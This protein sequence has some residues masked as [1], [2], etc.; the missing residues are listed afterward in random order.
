MRCFASLEATTPS[1]LESL[2]AVADRTLVTTDMERACRMLR[3]TK[4]TSRWH[5]I[6]VI[7]FG[8]ILIGG[9]L[10]WTTNLNAE[11]VNFET[12][13]APIFERHCVHCHEASQ[14]KGG[15]SLSTSTHAVAGG[16]SGPA[17]V[18]GK[19]DESLL[20]EYISGEKPE[21]PKNGSPLSGADVD[22]IRQWVAE[23]ARWP[24]GI[25][26]I[27]KKQNDTAWWSLK[28]LVRPEIPC[29]ESSWVRTPIDHFLLATL[30]KHSLVPSAEAD[31]RTLIRRLYFDLTG[32]PPAPRVVDAFEIDD[33]PQA[34]DKIVEQL[35]ASP[36]YGERWGRHWLD[37]ARYGDTH[38]YDKDKVRANAW[39]Y[40]DYV[41]RSFNS[42]KPYH[43]F[44]LEQLAGDRLFPGTCDGIVA[45][46]FLVAGPFDWVGQ[47][48]VREGT[49]DKAVTRNLD[50]DDMVAAAM[51]TFNSM[52]VQ[53]ARCHNHK[54]DPISQ[55]DYYSLQA[56]FA[57]I[58]R[59]DRP[60]DG[61]PH[62]IET[63]SHLVARLGVAKAREASCYQR[64]NELTD[65][66]LAS[67]D[68]S[69]Q[70]LHQ[71]LLHTDDQAFG[72]HSAI[73]AGPDQAKWI[74][75][76]LMAAA[77]I[78]NVVVV[79]AHDDYA[80]IGAGF[81]FP[82]RFKIEIS[83]SSEFDATATAI[84]DHTR[85]DFPN[86]G[87]TPLIFDAH[88]RRAR[89]IRITATRLAPEPAIIFLLLA[90]FR[91]S[92]TMARTWRN[93]QPFLR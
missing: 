1:A 91:C 56:V 47:T 45:T 5:F 15:F 20:V 9:C 14:P 73:E 58:D 26:L 3:T 63:R 50:R 81:G 90:R 19:P 40:R 28:P 29:V 37:V 83:E 86:P 53:C 69:L 36:R 25:E 10:I 34:Y 57:G 64:M 62:A 61:E 66:K 23:G 77:P 6:A 60:Y 76:D 78:E 42:D 52:T 80:G 89:F 41:I 88:H 82:R 51:N 68:Q 17:I 70:A 93:A 71:Q 46:G 54:F 22:S 72:Y 65:G 11:P 59:A 74:Q 13:V 55:Q 84:A 27:D 75:I 24:S 85:D 43:V 31:R 21:M 48:E 12:Q 79:A 33:H 32:L 4:S 18:P 16:E 39:P 30:Q 87:T 7:T 92:V 67:I 38:G 8:A 44:I 35:L 2:V 49:L